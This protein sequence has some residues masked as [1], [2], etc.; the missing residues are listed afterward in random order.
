MQNDF[1]RASKK[2][3]FE[4]T[5]QNEGCC[6]AVLN[7][8]DSNDYDRFLWSDGSTS[9]SINVSSNGI[10]TLEAWK[11]SVKYTSTIVVNNIMAGSFPTLSYAP[12]ARP[13][14]PSNPTNLVIIDYTK[15]LN[16]P[17]SYNATKYTLW[18]FNE[19]GTGNNNGA[20]RKIIGYAD[21]ETGFKNGDIQ[22]DG[23]DD[24]GN[25]VPTNGY[26]FVLR[27]ENCNRKCLNEKDTCNETFNYERWDIC[28]T[29]GWEPLFPPLPYPRTWNCLT[30]GLNIHSER[31]GTVK[32]LW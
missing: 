13:G 22:W 21:C 2:K 23:R 19:D 32:V 7:F 8:P 10:Y 27:L 24:N 14:D 3:E 12:E 31:E 4:L 5:S 6:N 17:F 25:Q 28:K 18:I 20:F 30:Q 26:N 29:S 15:G 1:S 9:S 11:N 16:E